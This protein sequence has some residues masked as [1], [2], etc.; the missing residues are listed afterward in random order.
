MTDQVPDLEETRRIVL[1]GLEGYPAKV[2]LFGSFARGEARRY[3]DI[4]V[5]ISPLEPLPPGLL[6][7]I[8]EALDQS[9]V[10]YPVEL[11]DLTTA[12]ESLRERVAAEGIPWNA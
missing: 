8:E 3:S 4:D 5:A 11:V 6:L 2:C 7:E 10:L 12:S 9:E 1:K